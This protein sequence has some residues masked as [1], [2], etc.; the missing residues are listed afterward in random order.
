MVTLKWKIQYEETD[1][2]SEM[3]AGHSYNNCRKETKIIQSPHS[4]GTGR[5]VQKNMWQLPDPDMAGARY[6][7]FRSLGAIAFHTAT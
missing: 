5:R 1:S 2:R 7:S 6:V 4:S 3:E